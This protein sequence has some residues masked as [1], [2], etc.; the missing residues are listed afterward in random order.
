MARESQD[1]VFILFQCRTSKFVDE[2]A[3]KRVVAN[4]I[5][6]FAATLFVVTPLLS[7]FVPFL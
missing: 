3:V 5:L 4:C 2:S 7:T 1:V 6:Q